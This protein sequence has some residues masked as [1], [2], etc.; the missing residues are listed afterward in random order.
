MFYDTARGARAT[1]IASP[2]TCGPVTVIS[3][4]QL[5][6]YIDVA[7]AIRQVSDLVRT[8]DHAGC[9]LLSVAFVA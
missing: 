9:D 8:V 1:G 6:A 2:A 5:D 7:F 3:A 4:R